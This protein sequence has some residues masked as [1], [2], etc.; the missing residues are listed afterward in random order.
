M[1]RA[2]F[3]LFLLFILGTAQAQS[4]SKIA[5]GASYYCV[6]NY[7]SGA[8]DSNFG[9]IIRINGGIAV[10]SSRV[11]TRTTNRIRVLR[12]RLEDGV[13]N[14]TAIRATLRNLRTT[15]TDV[16]RCINY[17]TTEKDETAGALSRNAIC[18]LV[19]G[20]NARSASQTTSEVPASEI[21]S[22]HECEI[23]NSAVVPISLFQSG[24]NVGSCSGTV[25]RRASESTGH[26]VMFAAHC[27][28]G[29]VDSIEIITPNGTMQTSNLHYYPGWPVSEDITQKDVAIAIFAETIPTNSFVI[30][31][32]NDLV[33]GEVAV[34]AGYGLDENQD[35]YLDR[36]KAGLV[37]VA[38]FTSSTITIYYEGLGSNTCSG[39]SG[40][41]IFVKRDGTWKL[42]GATSNG[43]LEL[44]GPGDTS[45]FSN[46]ADPEVVSWINTIVSGLVQ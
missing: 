3:F 44:C 36:L 20:T 32:S 6:S 37:K 13:G 5:N 15:R 38:E 4:T 1:Q 18:Q 23:G 17:G 43:I 41:P 33:S 7:T 21:I 16:R 31:G 30:H 34:I 27:V 14:A 24:Q 25:V 29:G 9:V 46:F 12:Q 19:A 28:E 40:G 8:S 26:V 2:I 39:D 22:G 10:S 11:L 42:I 35:A 45:N